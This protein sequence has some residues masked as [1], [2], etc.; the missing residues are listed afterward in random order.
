MKG[1]I[2]ED[3]SEEYLV[4]KE[5]Q[6]GVYNVKTRYKFLMHVQSN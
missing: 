5:E 6:N 1:P 4:W 2:L 3:V